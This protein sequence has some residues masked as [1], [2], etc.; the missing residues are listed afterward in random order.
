MLHVYVHYYYNYIYILYMTL[1]VSEHQV[2]D[3]YR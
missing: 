2:F 1:F 3:K